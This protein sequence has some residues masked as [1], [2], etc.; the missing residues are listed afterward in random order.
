MSVQSRKLLCQNHL[1]IRKAFKLTRFVTRMHMSVSIFSRRRC[2]S[3]TAALIPLLILAAGILLSEGL[4]WASALGVPP[5]GEFAL[6]LGLAVF[7]LVLVEQLYRRSPERGRWGVKPLCIALGALFGYDLYLYADAMLFGRLDV[8]IWVARGAA[9]ACVVPFVAVATVRNEG[10]TIEMHVSRR[11]LLQ[12]GYS[13]LMG[14]GLSQVLGSRAAAAASKTPKSLVIVFLTGAPSHHDTFDMKPDAPAEIRGE[15][16]PVATN[17]PGVEVCELMPRLA[18]LADRFTLIRSL[19]GF[20]DDFRRWLTSADESGVMNIAI[21][22]DAE[23]TAGDGERRLFAGKPA[24]IAADIKA[25]RDAG[26]AHLDFGFGGATV[27]E[28]LG[29]MQRFKREVL[30]LV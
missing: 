8:D 19:D 12:V 10:W 6:R 1:P 7:G 13:G 17:V 16:R 3:G 9:S 27:D 29:E 15:F 25:L 30:A 26:V 23:A 2:L 28:V 20:R 11:A 4:P 18:R 14:V 5:R 21:F 24:D 22:Y